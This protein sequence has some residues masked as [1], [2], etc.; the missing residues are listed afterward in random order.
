[1]LFQPQNSFRRPKCKKGKTPSEIAEDFKQLR[2]KNRLPQIVQKFNALKIG[3]D[4]KLSKKIED[5]SKTARNEPPKTLPYSEI[6]NSILLEILRRSSN[7]ENRP[8]I[9]AGGQTFS[10]RV[11]TPKYNR[12]LPKGFASTSATLSAPNSPRESTLNTDRIIIE[13]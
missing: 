9:Q 5:F 10:D 6:S 13:N 2:Q 1:M 7:I 11:L 12:R 3:N 4:V 8:L